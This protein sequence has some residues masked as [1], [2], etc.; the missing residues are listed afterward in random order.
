[1]LAIFSKLKDFYDVLRY[2]RDSEK[3]KG[4]GALYGVYLPGVLTMFGVIIYLRLGWVTGSIGLAGTAFII[5]LSCL[6][7]FITTLS[8]SSAATNRK[9][10]GG[11]TYYM[12]S[13]SLGIEMGSA[14]G[15]PLY[16]AQTLCISF[17]AVGFA[18]SLHPFFPTIP[19]SYM[20][21]GALCAMGMLCFSTGIAL[22]TQF[23]IFLIIAASLTSLFLGDPLPVDDTTPLFHEGMK[24]PFWAGFA[25]FFPAAT[26]VEAGVSMSGDLHSPRKALPLGTIAVLLTGFVVYLSL[27]SF[28]WGHAPRSLLVTDPLIVQH[29]ARFPLLITAG[30]WAATLSSVLGGLLAAPRTLQALARD[31]VVPAFFA[32]EYGSTKE[33]RF[34]LLLCFAIAFLGIYY[35]SINQIAPVLTMF[36][37]IA[38]AMLNLATGLE[39]LLNNPSWR[40]TFRVPWYISIT[41][42]VLCLMA[43]FMIDSGSTFIA[44][45]FVIA[46]YMYMRRRNLANKWDDIRHGVLLFLSR[47]VIYRLSGKENPSRSWRPNF[48]VFSDNPLKLSNMVNL[49]AA[50]TKDKGF[51]TLTSV[52]PPSLADQDRADR[53]KKMV[54]QFLGEKKIEALVEFTIDDS[55]VNGA[56]K[57]LS[58][59][60][61]G[62]I[63]PNTIVLG[64]M[65][66]REMLRECLQIM[67]FAHASQK[68]VVILREET[69]LRPVSKKIDVWWDDDSKKNSELMILLAHMLSSNRDWKGGSICIKSVVPHEN[70]RAQRLAYFKEFLAKSRL[71]AESEIYVAPKNDESFYEIASTFS[72]DA[73]LVFFGFQPL[74]DE[75]SLDAFEERYVKV[76]M[77]TKSLAHVAFVTHSEQTELSHIFE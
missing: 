34:A 7:V 30:I 64:E 13:R 26:G 11:G 51:L 77:M 37:L 68:N 48:L 59:Y 22:N 19:I 47:F 16:L 41:G 69:L 62:S 70:A 54:N 24:I 76:Q 12:I 1:M 2:G 35:G 15:V 21:I 23:L 74:G 32:K 39:T 20:G 65:Q 25:I 49:T 60:G 6:I 5:T 8:I 43:M 56:K 71:A 38:Y 57:L 61:I 66:N 33:P 10:E 75:E 52:F 50:I 9:V 45:F 36:Y 29:I 53:W 3:G 27:S 55:L 42:F 40:P 44:L 72:V 31:E 46:I 14:V 18:E 4:Y 63:T 58:T 67:Q 73:D 28:L 17:C